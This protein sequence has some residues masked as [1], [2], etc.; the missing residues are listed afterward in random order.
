MN[1]LTRSLLLLAM[2]AV[3]A[4]P[5]LAAKDDP[6]TQLAELTKGRVA[7]KPQRCI[8]LSQAYDSQVIDKTTIAYRIGSTWYVNQLK[9]G[10]DLLD[11]RNIL[12]THT[13]GSQLCE[14]DNIRLVERYSG[15][16]NGFVVLGQFVP[17]KKPPTPDH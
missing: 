16:P 8:D 6:A 12:V 15:I 5:A 10:A 7:G 11:S 14:L 13:V 1:T 17:Y 9:S 2:G 3:V 4:G